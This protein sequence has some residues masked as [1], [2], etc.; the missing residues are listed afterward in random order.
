MC[1]LAS[2]GKDPHIL[3]VDIKWEKALNFSVL[4]LLP[5]GE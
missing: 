3:K 1:I 2:E 4:L 5:L